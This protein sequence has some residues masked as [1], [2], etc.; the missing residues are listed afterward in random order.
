M[1]LFGFPTQRRGVVLLTCLL[2][3]GACTSLLIGMVGITRAELARGTILVEQELVRALTTAALVYAKEQVRNDD[4]GCDHLAEPWAQAVNL[5]AEGC[6]VKLQEIVGYPVEVTCRIVDEAG[7]LNIATAATS[8]LIQVGLEDYLGVIQDWV[9]A[10]DD[11]SSGGAESD[12]YERTPPYYRCKNKAIEFIEELVFLRNVTLSVVE[13]EDVN[14]NGVLDPCEQDGDD[15]YPSDNGDD[16]LDL[17][18]RDLLTARGDGRINLN[19][20]P[21]AVLKAI[22]GIREET[23]V[24]IDEWRRGP[25]A[26]E[27]ARRIRL[28]GL[29]PEREAQSVREQLLIEALLS[30][31]LGAKLFISP[32]AMVEWYEKNKDLLA[33]PEVRIA[34]VM[35]VRAGPTGDAAAKTKIAGLR[36]KVLLGGDFAELARKHSAGPWAGKGG[37]LDP[38]SRNNSGNVFAER[39]FQLKKPGDVTDIFVTA[40]GLH[41]LKLEAVRPGEVPAFKEVQGRIRRRLG[42]KLR[43]KHITELAQQARRKTTVRVFWHNISWQAPPRTPP[44]PASP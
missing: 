44:E 28:L 13:G 21:V 29:G 8:S 40:A 14:G 24:A 41:F 18:A 35:T 36:R 33:G 37:L 31:K 43:A 19:T 26:A 3:L 17:G 6:F 15:T 12:Y 42:E 7:K 22:P 5:G 9:D 34:R 20:A 2:V 23:A 25:D 1:S 16:V 11:A 32:K 39:V 10:D 4:P 38:M 30:R 27:H